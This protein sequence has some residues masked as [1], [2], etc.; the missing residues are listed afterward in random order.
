MHANVFS[1]CSVDE[2]DPGMLGII[3]PVWVPGFP[4]L[5]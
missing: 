1:T 3:Y 5:Y 4:F 2:T